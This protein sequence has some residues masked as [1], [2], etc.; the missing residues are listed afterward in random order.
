MAVRALSAYI[1]RA[2]NTIAV[3]ESHLKAQYK[4]PKSLDKAAQ[5]SVT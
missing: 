4:R 5:A 1:E 3:V 2:M